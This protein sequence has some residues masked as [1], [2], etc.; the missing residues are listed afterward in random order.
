VPSLAAEHVH[1]GHHVGVALAEVLAL[2][3]ERALEQWAPDSIAARLE[4]QDGQ[5][6]QRV[7][8]LHAS[9][10]GL[11]AISTRGACATVCNAHINTQTVGRARALEQQVAGSVVAR[12]LVQHRGDELSV[13]ATCLPVCAM[14]LTFVY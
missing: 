12:L 4:V 1:D 7:R 3:R 6:C 8:D 11:T 13:H 5:V 10:E 14:E 9:A 2:D